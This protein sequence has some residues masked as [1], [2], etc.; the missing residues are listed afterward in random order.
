MTLVK[1]KREQNIL[2]GQAGI[3][4]LKLETSGVDSSQKVEMEEP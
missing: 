2:I 4:N 3:M 1:E